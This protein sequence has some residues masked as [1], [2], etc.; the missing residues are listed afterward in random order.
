MFFAVNRI[1]RICV[2]DYAD[3]VVTDSVLKCS[4]FE[5]YMYT[6]TMSRDRKKLKKR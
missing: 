1:L 4:F 2:Q 5:L 3:V 6:Y